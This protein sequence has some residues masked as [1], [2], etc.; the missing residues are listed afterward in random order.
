MGDF[1]DMNATP[2]GK[3]PLPAVQSKG[4]GPRVDMASSYSDIL[5][6]MNSGSASQ[7]AAVAQQAPAQQQQMHQLHQLH[8]LQ[9]MQ[10]L[11]MQPPAFDPAPRYRQP[12]PRRRVQVAAPRKASRNGG[13]GG[14]GGGGVMARVRQYKSSLLVTLIVFLVLSYAAPRL[15]QMVPQLLTP[16]GKF[17]T[18]GLLLI[19]ASCGGI[20]RLLDHYVKC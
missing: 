12:A 2:L 3:L 15:A 16:A 10:Q 6:E 1:E 19:A 18:L 7:Q 9:Q 11:Q 8:Q 13:G 20:H 4:D 17:N 14:G 5:K